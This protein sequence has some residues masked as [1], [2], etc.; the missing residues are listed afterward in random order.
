MAITRFFFAI[1]VGVMQGVGQYVDD[2]TFH[3]EC[4]NYHILNSIR[5]S[6]NFIDSK[7]SCDDKWTCGWCRLDGS[8]ASRMPTTSPHIIVVRMRL[9]GL[10]ALILQCMKGRFG[11]TFAFTGRAAVL[12]KILFWCGPV[13]R[14]L[15]ANLTTITCNLRYCGNGKGRVCS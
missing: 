8:A 5:R 6:L 7:S 15:F 14:S 3:A 9:T 10:L 11:L 12:G 4:Q 2:V 1:N 13:A